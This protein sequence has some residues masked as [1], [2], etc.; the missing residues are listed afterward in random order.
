M[1]DM[2]QAGVKKNS[3]IKTLLREVRSLRRDISLLFPPESLKDYSNSS[4]ITT[5]LTRARRKYPAA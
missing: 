1:V 4:V 2:V 3:E 5:A